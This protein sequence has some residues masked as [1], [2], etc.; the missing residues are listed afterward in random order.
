MALRLTAF[1][2]RTA[3]DGPADASLLGAPSGPAALP[4]SDAPP[5]EGA[6]ALLDDQSM[7]NIASVNGQLRASSI[8][9]IAALVGNYPEASLT[10]VRGWMLQ[11]AD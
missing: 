3:L 2:E 5:V 4:S 7:I 1:P 6:G 11:E 9:R 10:I 8:R